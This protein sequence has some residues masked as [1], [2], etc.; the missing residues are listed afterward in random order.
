MRTGFAS[1][2]L[3]SADGEMVPPTPALEVLRMFGGSVPPQLLVGGRGTAW[4]S[5]DVVLKPLDMTIDALQWQAEVLP[6]LDGL[7]TLRVSPPVR[8]LDDTLVVKGW[9]AWRHVE[10]QHVPGS[11]REI[12]EVGDQLHLATRTLAKPAFID[13][14]QDNWAVGDRVAW[15]ET[16]IDDFHD[17]PHL[18]RLA[19]HR[20][21]INARHQLIHGDLTGNVLFHPQLPPAIIDLSPYWRP[22]AFASAIVVADALVWEGANKSLLEAV[23]GKPDFAQYVVRALIYRLVTD[24]LTRADHAAT[25]VDNDRYQPVV[26]LACELA[27]ATL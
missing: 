24:S 25:E 20:Q 16:P 12:I 2:V 26:T 10:G 4:R 21:P 17:A 14:R 19:D 5:G 6:R 11:W 3:M 15:D 23:A 8:A 7:Q 22:P 18:R 9:T 27:S 13:A 1:R